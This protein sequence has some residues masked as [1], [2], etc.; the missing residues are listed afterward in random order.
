MSPWRCVCR[1][2]HSLSKDR[3]ASAPSAPL[4]KI[5]DHSP[6]GCASISY[7]CLSGSYRL[8]LCYISRL[9]K[10]PCRLLTC[11][12]PFS[13]PRILI[14]DIDKYYVSFDADRRSKYSGQSVVR[15]AT[16]D[17]FSLYLFIR[18]ISPKEKKRSELYGIRQNCKSL[19]K[20]VLCFSSNSWNLITVKSAWSGCD[21][22]VCVP[23]FAES[24]A[25]AF[26]NG[27]KEEVS[28]DTA[29]CWRIQG[30]AWALLR[31]WG[32]PYQVQPK[33]YKVDIVMSSWL[34]KT[35]VCMQ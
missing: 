33:T 11:R 34:C 25:Y 24:N 9:C 4:G 7:R 16:I 18:S 12:L 32:H 13:S 19:L 22:H 29:S 1:A 31:F 30:E 17:L 14:P 5:S 2:Q 35:V 6:S 10:L 28:R 26:V 21:F 20:Y 23:M 27:W 15:S 3:G 8:V